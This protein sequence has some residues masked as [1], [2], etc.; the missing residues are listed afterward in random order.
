MAYVLLR[1]NPATVVHQGHSTEKA[2]RFLGGEKASWTTRAIVGRQKKITG[3]PTTRPRQSLGHGARC[4][5]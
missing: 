3:S 4:S 5:V 1:G 2:T